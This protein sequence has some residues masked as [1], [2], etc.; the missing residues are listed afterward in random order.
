LPACLTV[1]FLG[2]LAH[3]MDRAP[4]R[5]RAADRR[6]RAAR[7]VDVRAD[8]TGDGGRPDAGA[9]GP[10]SCWPSTRARL[11]PAIGRYRWCCWQEILAL[12]TYTYTLSVRLLGPLL[13]LGL[14]VYV[15]R[16]RWRPVVGTWILY[17]PC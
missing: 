13:A 14:V 6:D 7:P 11:V 2:A 10:A 5:D 12:L 1:I 17:G 4:D 3:R 16:E 9:G 8:A 15:N